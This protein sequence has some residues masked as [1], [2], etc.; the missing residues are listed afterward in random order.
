MPAFCSAIGFNYL[1][2]PSTGLQAPCRW[3]VLINVTLGSVMISS[4][5]TPYSPSL[6][7]SLITYLQLHLSPTSLSIYLVVIA[8]VLAALPS[9]GSVTLPV[10]RSPPPSLYIYLPF[11]TLFLPI[12]CFLPPVLSSPFILPFFHSPLVSLSAPS[13]LLASPI[14][15]PLSSYLQPSILLV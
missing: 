1:T 12:T 6:T 5:D 8:S 14:T 11:Y 10:A 4:H 9:F 13:S 15:L 2:F 3:Q 7:L